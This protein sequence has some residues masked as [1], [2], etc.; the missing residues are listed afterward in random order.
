[1][2]L[3]DLDITKCKN[4]DNVSTELKQLFGDHYDNVLQDFRRDIKAWIVSFCGD[5]EIKNKEVLEAAMIN[6]FFMYCFG[7]VNVLNPQSHFNAKYSHAKTDK[8]FK[9]IESMTVER[10]DA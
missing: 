6:Y 8:L 7:C 2:K 1:M 9:E 5:P 3:K 4:Y 10:K